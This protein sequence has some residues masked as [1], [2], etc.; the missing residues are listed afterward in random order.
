[1]SA[2][3]V[4]HLQHLHTI[5]L[6]FI[7]FTLQHKTAKHMLPGQYPRTWSQQ[8]VLPRVDA[9][10][11]KATAIWCCA[12]C[13]MTCCYTFC[14]IIL[15][16]SRVVG[17]VFLCCAKGRIFLGNF[18]SLLKPSTYSTKVRHGFRYEMVTVKMLMSTFCFTELPYYSSVCVCFL[19][20]YSGH[21]IRWTY[22]PRAHRRKVT[23]DFSSTFFLRCVPYF[24]S[25]EGFSLSFP[26]STVKS[27]FVY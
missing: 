25:R 1:M 7:Q 24:F 18:A 19:A 17:G 21:Q 12:C 2:A 6:I 4:A 14:E 5:I 22:Q 13:T 26:S 9:C 8:D 27:N 11:P 15:K 23:Q 10:L 3:H 20:I 16:P